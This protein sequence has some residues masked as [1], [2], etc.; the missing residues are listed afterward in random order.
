MLKPNT[1]CSVLNLKETLESSGIEV[2]LSRLIRCKFAPKRIY[3]YF[4]LQALTLRIQTPNLRQNHPGATDPEANLSLKA[5]ELPRFAC[6]V[7]C[8]CSEPEGAG[9][10][11]GEA[12][13]RG[14]I[15]RL[16]S[17]DVVKGGGGRDCLR[18]GPRID[19]LCVSCLPWRWKWQATRAANRHHRGTVCDEFG[20]GCSIFSAALRHSGT[21]VIDVIEFF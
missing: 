20:R 16:H 11:G 3:L 6:A 13:F 2:A 4:A 7:L 9:A 1:E 19:W 10:G 21:P 12:P 8:L 5:S 15:Q 14:S 17:R 18:R